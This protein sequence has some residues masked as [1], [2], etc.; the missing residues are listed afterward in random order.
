MNNTHAQVT[1]RLSEYIDDELDL[2]ERA[3]VEEH[4]AACDECRHAV[5]DLRSIVA[6]ATRL[7]DSWPER[8]LWDGV[9]ERIGA[10]N[11]GVTRFEAGSRR[12]F[13]FTMPQIAAAGIALMVLSGGLVYV[14]LSDA[15]PAATAVADRGA[16]PP[17]AGGAFQVVF[18]D[19]HYDGAVA[20]LERTLDQGRNRLDPVTVRVLEENLAA[21]DKAIDQSR[22]ALEADPANSFLS[23][24]L[25]SARQRKLALL[26]R[27]TALTTGS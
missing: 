6:A 24:H 3:G 16:P 15:P 1:G 22:R 11:H 19:P 7:P 17:D 12:R 25:V 23:N 26:R 21:I 27:A 20:D 4:L 18:A 10:R 2:R 9:T 5:E 8:E 13:S 14:A